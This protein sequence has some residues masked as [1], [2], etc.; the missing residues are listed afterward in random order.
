MSIFTIVLKKA[1]GL[2]NL[3]TDTVTNGIP[4]GAVWTCIG[5]Q[6]KPQK[7]DN[8]INGGMT[9]DYR[10]PIVLIFDNPTF[11]KHYCY[12]EADDEKPYQALIGD[13]KPYVYG[14]FQIKSYYDNVKA[15]TAANRAKRKAALTKKYGAGNAKLILDGIVRLGMT[16]AMCRESWGRT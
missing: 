15:I 9:N 3:E 12:L 1:N 5:V 13:S 11:G 2:I 6:V 8:S 14:R 16:K 7:K 10:S 4:M